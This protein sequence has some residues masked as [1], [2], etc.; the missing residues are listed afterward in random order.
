MPAHIKWEDGSK[1]NGRHGAYLVDGYLNKS[2]RTK[3]KTHANALFKQYMQGKLN[4]LPCPTVQE[5]YDRWIERQIPPLIRRS[6]VRDNK[7]AFRKH[8]LPR[9]GKSD[10]LSVTTAELRNFQAD[11]FKTGLAVKSVRNIIDSSLRAMYRDAR[12]EIA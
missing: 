12:G 2:L 1:K 11:L 5:F 10:L 6:R 8:I 3:S 4:L 9:F 7:Q